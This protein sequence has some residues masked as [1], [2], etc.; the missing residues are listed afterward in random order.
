MKSETNPEVGKCLFWVFPILTLIFALFVCIG[1]CGAQTKLDT[2]HNH[3]GE[4]VEKPV[5]TCEDWLDAYYLR[6][7]WLDILLQLKGEYHA[8]EK[9]LRKLVDCAILETYLFERINEE[10]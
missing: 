8:D 7:D 4:L 2:I 6:L 10:Q 1:T 5:W 9:T 3:M